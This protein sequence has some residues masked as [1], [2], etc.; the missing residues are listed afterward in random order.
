MARPYSVD[1]RERV[2]ASIDQGRSVRATAA[3]FEVSASS[4]VKWSQRQR[5]TGSV[6]PDKMGGYVKPILLSEREWLAARLEAEPDVTLR[7]LVAELNARG[8]KASYGSLWR[9]FA[10]E[11]ISF[12]K[13]PVR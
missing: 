10:R 7:S 11:G 8:I 3:L 5:R 4:V 1:L 13:K 12:K 9:H 6:A 2:V